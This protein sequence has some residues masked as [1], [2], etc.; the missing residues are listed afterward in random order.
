MELQ[1]RDVCNP[2]SDVP[3]GGVD[4]AITQAT[5]FEALAEAAPQRVAGQSRCGSALVSYDNPGELQAA[6]VP[7]RE[8]RALE[9]ASIRESMPLVE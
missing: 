7:T 6:G 9:Q 1:G 2:N 4:A 5:S 8:P 3:P